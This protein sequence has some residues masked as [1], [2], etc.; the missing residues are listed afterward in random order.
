M[1]RPLT[2]VTNFEENLY[3]QVTVEN[4]LINYILQEFTA[5]VS[6]SEERD[7]ATISQK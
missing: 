7:F 6:T 2:S 3:F 1:T 4:E 5:Q